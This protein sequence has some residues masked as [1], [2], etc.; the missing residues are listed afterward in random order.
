VQELKDLLAEKNLPQ[1][2]KKEDLIAR[3]VEADGAVGN[4]LAT[5]TANNDDDDLLGDLPP[6]PPSTHSN[7][8]AT[9]ES[10][11][12]APVVTDSK[13]TPVTFDGLVEQSSTSS[14]ADKIK[15]RAERF[16]VP[17]TDEQKKSVRGARFGTAAQTHENGA[18]RAQQQPLKVS[19]D[20][21]TLKRRH[22]RFGMGQSNE[23]PSAKKPKTP[24]EH[25][26]TPVVDADEL[27]KRKERAAKFGMSV[28]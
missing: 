7:P 4:D 15:A 25:I 10:Q 21:D 3:L 27:A 20:A 19:I 1:H 26:E 14:D 2:G 8:P 22:E 11:T 24:V 16:G 13:F 18:Q 9:V 17:L 5:A 12:T 23:Q 6:P 28:S